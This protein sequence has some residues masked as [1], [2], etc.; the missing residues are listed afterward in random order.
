MGPHTV[1]YVTALAVS[2]VS[3]SRNGV[4]EIWGKGTAVSKITATYTADGLNLG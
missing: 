3:N 4:N 2:G 1:V